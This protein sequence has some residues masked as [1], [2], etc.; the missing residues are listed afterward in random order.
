MKKLKF[1]AFALISVLLCAGFTACGDDDKDE[2]GTTNK[3]E[4]HSIAGTW[5][6]V[7]NDGYDTYAIS[8]ILDPDG[9]FYVIELED[10]DYYYG[11]YTYSDPTLLLRYSDG[12]TSDYHVTWRDNNSII[13]D[14]GEGERIT[15]TRQ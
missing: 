5:V 4:S 2:P 7:E 3:T 15:L 9:S 12:D 11:T 13:L 1:I 8:M 14:D 10:N 6:G